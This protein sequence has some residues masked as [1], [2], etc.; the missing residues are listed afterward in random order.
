VSK[1]C[2]A[3][4]RVPGVAGLLPIADWNPDHQW[5]GKFARCPP[6]DR[7]AVIELLGRRVGVFSELDL[8][9]RQQTRERQ[10]HR[11]ANDSLLRE[12]SVEHP[13]RPKPFLQSDGGPMDPALNPDVFTKD[14]GP[15][16]PLQLLFDDHSNRIDQIDS[17]TGAR[18]R[19]GSWQGSGPQLR[20]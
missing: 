16:I 13:P 15:R 17:R 9:D 1:N 8:G 12:R 2:L 14:Y 5:R 3:G 4:Y 7:S 10:P 19:A 20:Q 6:A 18:G 11:P